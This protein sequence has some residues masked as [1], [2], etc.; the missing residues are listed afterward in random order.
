LQHDFITHSARKCNQIIKLDNDEKIETKPK[1]FLNNAG[2]MIKAALADLG[3]IWIHK[4]S[5]ADLLAKKKLISILDKYTKQHFNVYV[6]Y[7]YQP[8]R[9]PKI[10]A[11]MDFFT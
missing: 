3:F 2:L 7:E 4:H 6:Y 9:A 10:Q 11:F 8:Y 1:L 5:V